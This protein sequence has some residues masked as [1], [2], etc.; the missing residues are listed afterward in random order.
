VC[1][2]P[3]EL[4][5]EPRFAPKRVN[6]ESVNV[7]VY[8]RHLQTRALAESEEALF[9]DAEGSRELG[10]MV[11]DGLSESRAAALTPPQHRREFGWSA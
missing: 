3:V 6:H 5:D 10:G 9:K 4:D 1:R 2:V 7:R 11:C 8:L